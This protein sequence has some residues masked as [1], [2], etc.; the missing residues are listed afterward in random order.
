MDD[1][2]FVT[3]LLGA[4]LPPGWG[5]PGTIGSVSDTGPDCNGMVAPSFKWLSKNLHFGTSMPFQEGATIPLQ[6]G[7]KA[8]G[9]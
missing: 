8:A 5:A 4:G 7:P 6:S 1:M 3:R 9:R 2:V